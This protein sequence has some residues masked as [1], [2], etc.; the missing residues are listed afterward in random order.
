MFAQ[1][2]GAEIVSIATKRSAFVK[3]KLRIEPML[4]AGV[5]HLGQTGLVLKSPHS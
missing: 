3:L 5:F 1:I 2:T 4:T